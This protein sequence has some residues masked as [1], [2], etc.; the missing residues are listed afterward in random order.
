MAVSLRQIAETAGVHTSTV[1]LALRNS[2]KIP[3]LTRKSIQQV[4]KS[5]GYVPN[6]M[7][8]GLAGANTKTIG[9]LVPK[10]RDSFVIDCFGAQEAW[11]QN[12]DYTPLLAVTHN[13][14]D[15]ELKAIDEIV[16]R[17]ADGLIINYV[18]SSQEVIEKIQKLIKSGGFV[19]VLGDASK[20]SGIDS[21]DQHF[22]SCGYETAKHLLELGHT[23]I[24][25]TLMSLADLRQQKRLEGYRK[26]LVEFG[27]KYDPLLVF[28]L[29]YVRQDVNQLRQEAM[30]FKERPTAI[31]AYNDDL[32]AELMIELIG[33]GYD[34]PGDIAV[35][36]VNDG[37]YSDKLKVP[38]TT[39][40]LP[41]EK[42][43]EKLAQLVIARIE[44]NEKSP[45]KAFFEGELVVRESTGKCV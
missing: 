6:L 36:G 31:C 25:F 11:M 7:A 4:A 16:G 14:E 22:E 23:K 15:V 35:T 10:L 28:E 37:W 40:K 1:S 3:E 24:A 18:P 39:Y 33:A 5:L 21:V 44:D 34:V 2:Q 38:L 32:A 42:M 8:R 29:D 41:T 19:A 30:S 26:A 45:E 12:N 27:I 43:G 13:K 20:I 17:G 9:V